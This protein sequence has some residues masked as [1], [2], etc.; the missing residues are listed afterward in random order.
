MTGANTRTTVYV[1]ALYERVTEETAGTQTVSHR[2]YIRAGN[3]VIAEEVITPQS[4]E[5]RYW[6]RDHLG[7]VTAIT[8]QAYNGGAFS[9]AGTQG[10]Y[11]R[12]SYAPWGN[13][14][15]VITALSNPANWL[16][17]PSYH[18]GFTGHE[19]LPELGLIH[20]NGRVYMPELGV[21]LSPDS[22]VQFPESTQNYNRYTYVGNNPLSYTDP[23]GYFSFKEFLSVVT[24]IVGA[25]ACPATAGAGCA[26]AAGATSGTVSGYLM[27]G[28]LSGALRGGLLGGLSA[29][30][31]F[32]IGEKFG[33]HLGFGTELFKKSLAH[34]I[35]QGALSVAGG[36]RFGDGAL[37]A[38][39]G[40]MA[41]PITRGIGGETSGGRV[42][43]VVTAAVI[44]GTASTIGGGKFANGAITAAFVQ[45]YNDNMGFRSLSKRFS[46]TNP[47]TVNDVRASALVIDGAQAAAA[48]A[49]QVAGEAVGPTIDAIANAAQHGSIEA[50]VCGGMGPAVCVDISV[51]LSGIG[52]YAG[53][54]R[55]DGLQAHLGLAM[56]YGDVNGWT[57]KTMVGGGAGLGAHAVGIISESGL[58][59]SAVYGVHQGGYVGS[60]AGYSTRV[61]WTRIGDWFRGP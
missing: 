12:Y 9:E 61:D 2:L 44:G 33:H 25:V 50:G 23:S 59:A 41:S 26:V 16:Q 27:T 55:G 6:H 54:G 35:T 46:R 49:A 40:S 24:T 57:G 29:G 45:A 3:A 58:A 30:M 37:G 28:S 14:R 53:Y 31:S 36:G 38:F 21:F 11:G 39:I 22:F 5:T 43:R 48:D 10:F 15:A 8:T 52:G 18:R 20:M 4:R 51:S 7:C 32:G 17:D 13:A 56:S 1:G 34:G 19:M 47:E 60:T 42:A